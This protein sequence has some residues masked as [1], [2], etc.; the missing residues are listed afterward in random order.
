MTTPTYVEEKKDDTVIDMLLLQDTASLF[1]VFPFESQSLIN[2]SEDIKIHSDD[3]NSDRIILTID[4]MSDAYGVFDVFFD[5]IEDASNTV[6]VNNK[7]EA[8]EK[9]VLCESDVTETLLES[10]REE[11]DETSETPDIENLVEECFKEM[12]ATNGNTPS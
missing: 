6:N 5:S 2:S 9:S 10:T 3:I 8:P 4:G 7:L 12:L 1:S 11:V